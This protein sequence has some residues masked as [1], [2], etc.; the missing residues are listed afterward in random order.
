MSGSKID[1]QLLEKFESVS[2][3]NIVIEVNGSSEEA[4][5]DINETTYPDRGERTT[6]LM[7]ALTKFTETVQKPI[8]TFLA[9][10]YFSNN[11]WVVDVLLANS[12]K[13]NLI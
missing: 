2:K 12:S 3:L 4:T 6:A 5:K 10:R 1:P 13:L 9:E 11:F 8:K 7:N